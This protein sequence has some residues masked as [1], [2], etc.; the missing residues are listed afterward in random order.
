MQHGVDLMQTDREGRAILHCTIGKG[1][2]NKS[3]LALMLYVDGIEIDTED[4]LA[5]P[6]AWYA[7]ELATDDYDST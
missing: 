7:T 1:S 4:F 2:P 3:L 6:A 5:T